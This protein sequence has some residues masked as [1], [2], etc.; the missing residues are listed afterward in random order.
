MLSYF[1]LSSFPVS[2][3]N[4]TMKESIF[5]NCSFPQV[6]DVSDTGKSTHIISQCSSLWIE[7]KGGE[8]AQNYTQMHAHTKTTAWSTQIN[9]HKHTGKKRKPFGVVTL[10]RERFKARWHEFM[11]TAL[12]LCQT[13]T[14]VF[15]PLSPHPFCMLRHPLDQSFWKMLAGVPQIPWRCVCVHVLMNMHLRNFWQGRTKASSFFA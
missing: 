15:L 14:V 5:L 10:S 13:S 2:L 8:H 11:I 9:M 1:R 6:L 4:R 7:M 12:C 3:N